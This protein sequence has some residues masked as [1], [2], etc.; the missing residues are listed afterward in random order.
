MRLGG[1]FTSGR[2]T[3][4]C[5]TTRRDTRVDP[6]RERDRW[7]SESTVHSGWRTCSGWGDA[8]LM[9][10]PRRIHSTVKPRG[11]LPSAQLEKTIGL[12]SADRGT[13][14][15]RSH[16]HQSANSCPISRLSSFPARHN[17]RY[18]RVGRLK[19]SRGFRSLGDDGASES[20]PARRRWSAGSVAHIRDCGRTRQPACGKN[21]PSIPQSSG[22]PVGTKTRCRCMHGGARP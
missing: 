4:R 1:V 2:A 18:S 10:V 3:G 6:S 7:H 11:N 9:A 13:P 16:A 14:V 20:Q 19:R 17:F 15:R 22:P 12:R 21:H 8:G 5:R